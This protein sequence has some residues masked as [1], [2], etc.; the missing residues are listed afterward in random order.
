MCLVS[1]KANSLRK[2]SKVVLRALRQQ[3]LDRKLTYFICRNCVPNRL[4]DFLS[5]S[6]VL[7]GFMRPCPSVPE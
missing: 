2:E 6:A 5:L 7:P 4:R 1:G 3:A